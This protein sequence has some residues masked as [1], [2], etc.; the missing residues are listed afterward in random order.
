MLELELVLDYQRSCGEAFD[1]VRRCAVRRGVVR[2][3]RFIVSQMTR[4]Q[5]QVKQTVKQTMI[6]LA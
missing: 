4:L 1:S 6:V 3:L 5:T 2:R